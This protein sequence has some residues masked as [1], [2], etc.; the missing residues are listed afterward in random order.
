MEKIKDLIG[1]KFDSKPVWGDKYIAT[2]IRSYEYRINTDFQCEGKSGK[3]PKEGL[4][5]EFLSLIILDSV[6]KTGKK[7][8][9]QTFLEG[10]KYKITKKKNE[11]SFTDDFNSSSES[12]SESDSK[13]DSESDNKSDSESDSEVDN[14]ADE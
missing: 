7:Y 3:I 9:P 2:K 14:K 6:I 5:Y 13:P 4:L 1:K 10:C 11:K 8:H 12:D